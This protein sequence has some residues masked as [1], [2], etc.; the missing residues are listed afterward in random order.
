LAAG[1]HRGFLSEVGLVKAS[2]LFAVEHLSRNQSRTVR[3]ADGIFRCPPVSR[4]E[5]QTASALIPHTSNRK[6]D[7]P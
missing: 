7:S 2:K 3:A 6:G 5:Q 1:T 4:A